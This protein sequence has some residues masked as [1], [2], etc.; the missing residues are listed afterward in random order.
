MIYWQ[1][2]AVKEI[3]PQVRKTAMCEKKKPDPRKAFDNLTKPMSL[4][5]K[6]SLLLA[7]NIEKI[8]KRKTCCGH[9]GEPGC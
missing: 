4:R 9:H 2:V 6:I 5:K 8:L 1:K 7:N 3:M